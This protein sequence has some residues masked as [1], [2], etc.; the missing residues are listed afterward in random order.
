MKKNAKVNRLIHEA[1]EQ[2]TSGSYSAEDSLIL[3]MIQNEG[4]KI[5]NW[6]PQIGGE[7]LDLLNQIKKRCQGIL[8]RHREQKS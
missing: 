5:D 1:A 4:Q 6:K 3:D 2:S 7:G 8:R